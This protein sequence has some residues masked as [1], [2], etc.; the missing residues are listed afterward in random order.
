[1]ELLKRR[2]SRRNINITQ[3]Y[4]GKTWQIMSRKLK[5]SYKNYKMKIKA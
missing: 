3:Q 1:V 5:C 2:T 4:G